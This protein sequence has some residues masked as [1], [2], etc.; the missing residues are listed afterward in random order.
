MEIISYISGSKGKHR[1]ILIDLTAAKKS[2][3]RKKDLVTLMEEI[4]DIVA[5]EL[6]KDEKTLPY[7]E[8]RQQIFRGK[9]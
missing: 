2:V 1:D 9:K 4:E 8:A 3:K 7:Q 6:S 5:L